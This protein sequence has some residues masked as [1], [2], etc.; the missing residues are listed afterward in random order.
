MVHPQWPTL[1]RPS[2][3]TAG[4]LV[5]EDIRRSLN[6]KVEEIRH[7]YKA[8]PRQPFPADSPNQYAV[9]LTT[10][11]QSAPSHPLTSPTEPDRR[12]VGTM[13]FLDGQAP[14]ADATRA[15]PSLGDGARG[16]GAPVV[17]AV[18]RYA[19]ASERD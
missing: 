8:D 1:S 16:A 19:V 3:A 5:A 7:H 11:A 6:S 17:P 12:Q 4:H 10:E 2:S 9:R 15:R 14:A 13:R 18:G